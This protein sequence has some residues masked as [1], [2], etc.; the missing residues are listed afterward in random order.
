MTPAPSSETSPAKKPL[1]QAR[2]SAVNGAVSGTSDGIGGGTFCVIRAASAS[3][4]CLERLDLVPAREGEE[5]FVARGA[6][7]EI[8]LE[9]A[10][11]GARRVLAP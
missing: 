1:S 7:R 5:G 4:I 3:N 2:C 6:V 8:A 9:H 11:D 10:L